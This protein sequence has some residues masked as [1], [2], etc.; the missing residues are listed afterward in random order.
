MKKNFKRKRQWI[1]SIYNEMENHHFWINLDF[2]KFSGEDFI[3]VDGGSTDGTLKKL[4][5][6]Q[7]IASIFPETTRG[8]RFNKG[9][10]FSTFDLLIFVH[11]RVLIP[12]KAIECLSQLK[13]YQRW[14]A[15][16]HKFD[17]IDLLLNMASWWSNHLRGDLRGIYYLDHI[18]WAERSLVEVVDGFPREPIF[19]DTIFCKKLMSFALPYRLNEEVIVSSIRFQKNGIVRQLFLNFISKIKYALSFN[20]VTI[21]KKYEKELN[22]NRTPPLS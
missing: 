5:E 17:K 9:Y 6:K 7:I 21:E 10:E 22:L 18:I 2:L 20:L 13:F 15:F 14:G 19:E 11:P 12:P 3:V 4:N 8:E 1:F 16:T